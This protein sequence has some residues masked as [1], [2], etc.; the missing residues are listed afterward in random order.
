MGGGIGLLYLAPAVVLGLVLLAG[1]YP[2]EQTLVRPLARA[3]TPVRRALPRVPTPRPA[4]RVRPRGGLLLAAR[5]AG[6]GPPQPSLLAT[7]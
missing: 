5:L 3:R 4:R 7:S 1:R 2:G 6:R